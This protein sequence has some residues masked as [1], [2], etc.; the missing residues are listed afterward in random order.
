MPVG[1]RND[2]TVERS[3]D[4]MAFVQRVYVC[5]RMT[6]SLCRI[7]G[8]GDDMAY[9]SLSRRSGSIRMQIQ[10]GSSSVTHQTMRL[11]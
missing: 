9:P 3:I 8:T 10:L 4:H 7:K 1:C 5:T 11:S 2:T 6:A